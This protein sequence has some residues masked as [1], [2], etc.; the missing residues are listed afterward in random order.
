MYC[1]APGIWSTLPPQIG[2]FSET[3]PLFLTTASSSVASSPTI[4]QFKRGPACVLEL[5]VFIS[6]SAQMQLLL[7]IL[8]LVMSSLPWLLSLQHVRLVQLVIV[9]AFFL[10]SILFLIILV[11]FVYILSLL[12]LFFLKLKL[13]LLILKPFFVT[14]NTLTPSILSR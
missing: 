1:L 2:S 5:L 9:S 12:V 3:T 4:T 14:D 13:D 10:Q 11:F 7:L 6:P 8:A